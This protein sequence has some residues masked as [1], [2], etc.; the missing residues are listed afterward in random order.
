MFNKKEF[1]YE[2]LYTNNKKKIY[3]GKLSSQGN[4]YFIEH[5]NGTLI[6]NMNYVMTINESQ[7]KKVIQ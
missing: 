2:I 7:I 1:E 4:N 5:T 3:V 6:I